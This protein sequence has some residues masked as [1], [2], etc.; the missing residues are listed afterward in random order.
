MNNNDQVLANYYE[1]ARALIGRTLLD[2]ALIYGA[3]N[4]EPEQ[5]PPGHA[6]AVWAEM[7]RLAEREGC[8]IEVAECNET[9]GLLGG[10]GCLLR[11]RLPEELLLGPG[12]QTRAT[13]HERAAGH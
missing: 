1:S 13:V 10:V 2:P 5:M 6:R 9:L 7:V 4:V 11:Y 3:L 12:E 8:E